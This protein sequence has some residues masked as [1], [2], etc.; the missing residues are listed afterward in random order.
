MRGESA[1][2]VWNDAAKGRYQ[3]KA[4]RSENIGLAMY[5]VH[6]SAKRDLPGTL[7][8][9]AE[10]GYTG[11]E[12]Y[13]AFPVDAAQVHRVLRRSGL[14]LTGWHVEWRELQPDTFEATAAYLRDVE[15]PLAVVPCLG[16][17]W[18][19]A[20][21]PE[22]ECEDTWKRHIDW[23]NTTACR[24]SK[25]GIRM[26]Y[27][28]HEHEF[29]LHYRGKPLFDFLFDNLS[30][31]IVAELDSGNCIEGGDDPL[32]VLEKYRS[33]PMI[34]HCKPYSQTC[35]FEVTLGQRE[36]ENDWAGM[37]MPGR[38][39]FLWKLVESE[40]TVLPELEN[41]R[42]CMEGLRRFCDAKA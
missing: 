32:R 4:G 15:C 5:T 27:H 38:Y 8:Q 28:N 11:I 33:R 10:L 12:F 22:Q 30:P 26:G 40:C 42:R 41:A 21:M 34:L 29:R 13:G 2:A 6:Q 19:I 3:M 39:D 14:A 25:E 35:G 7:A 17:K 31:E 1:K 37:L 18:N 16:G 9:V 20:H 36:D 24:L 23:L